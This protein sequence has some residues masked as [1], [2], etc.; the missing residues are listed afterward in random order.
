MQKLSN[1]D[2]V[3]K[4]EFPTAD[5]Y[6]NLLFD[7]NA[8]PTYLVFTNTQ[9]EWIMIRH[10]GFKNL[11]NWGEELSDYF[12]TKVIITCAQSNASFY[13]FS[14]FDKGEML[15]EIEYCYS[16][17]YKPINYGKRFDFEDEQ[18]GTKTEYDGEIDYIFDFDNIDE[19]SKHFGLEVQP[20]YDNIN[21]WTILKSS[22]RQKTVKD[23]SLKPKPW[24]KFW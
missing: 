6:N 20:D 15:R 17:D 21:E 16:E 3:T 22:T 18:P 13:H 8:K 9:P 5:L 24:W 12:K 2:N 7:D 10:N 23:F 1:I 4:G 19:Y 14:L 11:K